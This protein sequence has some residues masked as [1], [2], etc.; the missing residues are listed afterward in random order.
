[1]EVHGI[2]EMIGLT[3]SCVTGSVGSGEVVFTFTDGRTLTFYHE[4]DCCESVQVDD[5]VGDLSDLI[6]AP[7]TLAEEAVQ[8]E[9]YGDYESN[10][11]TFYKFATVQ[12]YVTIKWLGTSNGY[13][14]ESVNYKW[15]RA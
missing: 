10:T 15:G 2:S 13:Y 6:Y 7:I 4:Q 8:S 5:I 11:W 1:M 9:E 3:P 12:G 14:S